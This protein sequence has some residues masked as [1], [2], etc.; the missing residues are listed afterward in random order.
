MSFSGGFCF[1]LRKKTAGGTIQI[2]SFVDSLQIVLEYLDQQSCKLESIDSVKATFAQVVAMEIRNAMNTVSR[3]DSGYASESE[4]LSDAM[5]AIQAKN[6]HIEQL[7]LLIHELQSS[8][9]EEVDRSSRPVQVTNDETAEVPDLLEEIDLND[10][11]IEDHQTIPPTET[12]RKRLAALFRLSGVSTKPVN[13]SRS[14]RKEE[15]NTK[16]DSAVGTQSQA[17]EAGSALVAVIEESPESCMGKRR[18]K[19]LVHYVKEGGDVQSQEHAGGLNDF[20]EFYC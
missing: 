20:D 5:R 13:K 2:K 3:T 1:G 9:R 8:L 10:A 17:E 11:G 14:I 7:E 15:F 12:L 16:D 6:D 18:Q 19:K 4:N